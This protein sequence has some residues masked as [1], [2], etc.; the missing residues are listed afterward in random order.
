MINTKSNKP[1][2]FI[3]GVEWFIYILGFPTLFIF[4]LFLAFKLGAVPIKIAYG[5]GSLILGYSLIIL[6]LQFFNYLNHAK[7]H[8]KNHLRAKECKKPFVIF[9]HSFSE[10]SSYMTIKREIEYSESRADEYYKFDSYLSNLDLTIQNFGLVLVT[11]G[12][13]FHLRSKHNVVIIETPDEYWFPN[14]QILCADAKVILI[15]PEITDSLKQ[16]LNY[17]IKNKYLNKCVFV[18][19]PIS[20]GEYDEKE[21][22]FAMVETRTNSLRKDKRW[23]LASKTYEEYGIKIPAYNKLGALFLFDCNGNVIESNLNG[24]MEGTSISNGL[25]KLLPHI[26]SLDKPLMDSYSHLMPDNKYF[27]FNSILRNIP[28]TMEPFIYHFARIAVPLFIGHLI[29]ILYS[30]IE[31]IF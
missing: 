8:H 12:G 18:M 25:K 2:Y 29:L 4:L 1:N 28:S 9:L 21:A 30:V 15:A 20:E 23:E 10:E 31:I 17:L 13:Q 6:N 22:G 3:I 7:R 11:L 5:F 26:S 19:P 24:S 27:P 14:F 16:E